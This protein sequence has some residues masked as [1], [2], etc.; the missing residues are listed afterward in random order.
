MSDR[1]AV[2]AK[3]DE[4]DAALNDALEKFLADACTFH[5]DGHASTTV[6]KATFETFVKNRNIEFS[7]KV[8]EREL[9]GLVKAK[10]VTKKTARVDKR[11]VQA[12][13]GISLNARV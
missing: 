11:A 7:P 3:K 13:L 12:Y 10:G 1:Q 9:V 5:P 6:F 2:K 8:S 4:R